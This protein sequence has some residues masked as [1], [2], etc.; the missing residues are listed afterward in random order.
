MYK[1]FIYFI[2]YIHNM[3]SRKFQ[4]RKSK[5]NK[6]SKTKLIKIVKSPKRDKK[7][8]AVF[9]RNGRIK[10]VDFGARGYGDFIQ[11][12]KKSRQLAQMKK[13]SY[14]SRHKVRENF[15]NYTSPGSLSRYILWGKPTLRASISDY[16]KRFKL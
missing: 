15:R 14:I 1:Y 7:Y 13:R 16:K 5:S 3:S 6:S 2:L 9:S 11:Y 12:N 8:R 4:S 10:N